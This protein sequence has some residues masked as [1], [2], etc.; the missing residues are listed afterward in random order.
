MRWRR[1]PGLLLACALFGCEWSTDLQSDPASWTPARSD[2]SEID[3]TDAAEGLDGLDPACRTGK[4]PPQ[5][6]TLRTST[7]T[8]LSHLSGGT[9]LEG[10][11]A[12][13]G[14][15]ATKFIAAGSV[16]R[17]QTS[18]A[19]AAAGGIVQGVGGTSLTVDRCGNIY[20]VIGS[21]ENGID[22]TQ[23]FVQSP[24][25]H[26]MEK[27]LAHQNNPGIEM[28]NLGSCNQSNCHDFS[29]KLKWGVYF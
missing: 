26:R 1:A 28:V 20:A 11:H 6:L 18:R 25:V 21:L 29:S 9:C 8:G 24:T 7:A 16:Y 27:S 23:P 19:F 13:E 14:E 3:V 5:D 2:Q 15:A 4:S 10:C 22:Q 12:P 17:S